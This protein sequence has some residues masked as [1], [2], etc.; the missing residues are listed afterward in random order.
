MAKIFR[1]AGSVRGF[2][3]WPYL[4][5]I[6]TAPLDWALHTAILAAGSGSSRP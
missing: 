6:T 2:R 1:P 5:L 4:G 3:V